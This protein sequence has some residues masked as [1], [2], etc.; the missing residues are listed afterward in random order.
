MKKLLVIVLGLAMGLTIMSCT[1]EAEEIVQSDEQVIA[2]EAISSSMLLSYNESSVEEI[3]N[4]FD[5]TSLSE[6]Q[7]NDLDYYVEMVEAFL[8]NDNLEVESQESDNEDYEMM[9]V[10]KTYNLSKEE[11]SYT[12][13]YNVYDFEED[14]TT[15]EATTEEA[16][17]E[18]ATTEE[19]TSET[20]TETESLAFGTQSDNDGN[21]MFNDED[22]QYATQAIK[23][24]LVYG[25]LTY[26]VEGK[27]LNVEGKEIIRVRSFIDEDNFVLVNYQKDETEID[28]E[29]FFFQMVE[30]GQV[31][32]RSKVMIFE[33]E[34]MQHVQLEF[35]D[36][37]NYERYQ[38]HIRETDGVTYIHINYNIS[39][40]EETSKGNIH[41]TKTIDSETGE[42]IYT[43]KVAPDKGQG[44]EYNKRH[45][46]GK[47]DM[48][49]R[50]SQ[51]QSKF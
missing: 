38:F 6:N 22:D 12:L 46:H 30:N 5:H 27:I 44:S 35:I 28:K 50:P 32:T 29:K 21:F 26:E 41:L 7:I 33:N 42:A 40:E 49:D 14:T 51:N 36:G 15:E 20:S 4:T 45:Q 37:D 2:L 25:D 43:Y 19:A 17:T 8:G 13:Y 1:G 48:T 9:M 16:T 47:N 23:G 11:M 31:M 18:E 3:K 24:I 39:T 10:Y 34:N